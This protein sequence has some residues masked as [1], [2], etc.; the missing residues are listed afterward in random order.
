MS[1]AQIKN[2]MAELKFH[3]MLQNLDGFLTEAI[4]E[5]WSYSEFL[6]SLIQAENDSRKQ[7]KIESKI[8]ASKLKTKPAFEDIDF[9]AKRKDFRFK[10]SWDKKRNTINTHKN[11]WDQ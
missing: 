4:K 9:S 7:K 8:K 1:M 11:R 2:T 10:I 3:G 5:K 6:D